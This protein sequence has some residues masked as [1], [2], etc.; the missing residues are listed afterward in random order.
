MDEVQKPTDSNIAFMLGICA[1]PPI[2]EFNLKKA[3]NMLA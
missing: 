1:V 2:F 3:V